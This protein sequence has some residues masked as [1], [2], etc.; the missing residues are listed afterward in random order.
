MSEVKSYR[1][2]DEM[3]VN[4]EVLKAYMPE[5]NDKG[6]LKT[7]LR[8][9]AEKVQSMDTQDVV[10]DFAPNLH[11]VNSNLVQ[12]FIHQVDTKTDYRLSMYLDGHKVC[13]NLE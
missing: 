1:F 5:L 3:L 9:A 2:D 8:L 7:C 13:F 10:V 12:D 6:L 4:Y 11:G